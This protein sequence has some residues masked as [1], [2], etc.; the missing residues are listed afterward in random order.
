MLKFC[1]T[2]IL[3]FVV[4]DRYAS[5]LTVTGAFVMLAGLTWFTRT[6]WDE[7]EAVPLGNVK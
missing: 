7:A 5:W 6:Q 1:V 4:F 3:G 2:I